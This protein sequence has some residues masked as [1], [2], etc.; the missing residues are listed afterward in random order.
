MFSVSTPTG[1]LAFELMSFPPSVLTR[2][3]DL[4]AVSAATEMI[5][6]VFICCLLLL[7][8]IQ[9]CLKTLFK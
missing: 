5:S 7:F 8:F 3:C 6:E 2:L 1:H 9:G 4:L